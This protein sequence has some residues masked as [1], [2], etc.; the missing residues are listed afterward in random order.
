[1]IRVRVR[2]IRNIDD[3]GSQGSDRV[4]DGGHDLIEWDGLER[5]RRQLQPGQRLE[6]E[7]LRDGL[8][9]LPLTPAVL[10]VPDGAQGRRHHQPMDLIAR[11]GVLEECAAAAE[12]LVVGVRRDAQDAHQ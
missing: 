11:C 4:E 9:L 1:M 6:R 7:C 12:R 10:V 3:I 5:R 2:T 8:D